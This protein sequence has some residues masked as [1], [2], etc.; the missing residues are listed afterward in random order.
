MEL[1]QFGALE[2]HPWG[3]TDADPGCADRL[4]FDLDPGPGIAWRAVVDAAR[5]VRDLLAEAGLQ[6]FVRTTGG[7]GL[8]VV[9]PLRP[10]SPWDSASAFAAAFARTMALMQPR[11]YVATATRSKREERIF[12]DHLRNRRGATAVASFSLRARPGAPVAMPLRWNELGRM[13]GGAHFDLRRAGLRL[14]RLKSHP[15]ENWRDLRQG[16]GPIED[17]LDGHLEP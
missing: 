9:A 12:I 1:V 4:V 7:K 17:L 8:H 11:R 15:W 14:A 16:L 10:A 13:E 2:F 6:S 5:Q 3:A